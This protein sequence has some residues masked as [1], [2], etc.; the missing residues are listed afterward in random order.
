MDSRVGEN[1]GKYELRMMVD[2]AKVS[3]CHSQ[4]V[5]KQDCQG[6]SPRMRGVVFDSY[7]F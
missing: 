7:A 6:L 4:M 2:F 1:D 3:I 5:E